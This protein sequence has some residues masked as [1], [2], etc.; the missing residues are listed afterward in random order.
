M[1]FREEEGKG[2]AEGF[3]KVSSGW[4][5]MA[6]QE[7]IK[8]LTNKEGETSTNADG[9]VAWKFPTKVIDESDPDFDVIYDVIL[10]ANDVGEKWLVRYY[11]AANNT[12]F[13]K[14][15]KKY[16]GDRSFFEQEIIE[17]VMAGQA[18]IVGEGIYFKFAERPNKK[19]KDNPYINIVAWAPPNSTQADLDAI[20]G[21]KGGGKAAGKAAEKPPANDDEF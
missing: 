20:S 5:K 18:Q 4:H 6:F 10:H 2:K 3:K 12:K 15:E 8:I 19:D 21:D 16:P 1:K 17:K 14:L 7:G 11:K 13:E 9:D